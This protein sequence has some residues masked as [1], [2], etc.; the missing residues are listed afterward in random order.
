[1]IGHSG[2]TENQMANY[3]SIVCTKDMYHKWKSDTYL[4]LTRN[5]IKWLKSRLR[6]RLKLLL[7]QKAEDIDWTKT[8]QITWL[9]FFIEEHT[10]WITYQQIELKTMCTYF[11]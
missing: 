6:K 2:E 4:D 7:M 5:L 11:T 1:M 8:G 10:P 9:L 3:V